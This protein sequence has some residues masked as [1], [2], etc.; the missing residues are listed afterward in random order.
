M[1]AT[2]VEVLDTELGI[3]YTAP[4]SVIRAKGFG[5]DRGFGRQWALCLTFW[6]VVGDGAGQPAQLALALGGVP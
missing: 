4:M 6:R 3:T 5:L 2:R 1:G